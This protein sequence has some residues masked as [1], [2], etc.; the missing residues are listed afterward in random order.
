[1]TLLEAGSSDWVVYPP[2]GAMRPIF[3]TIFC[4]SW[5]SHS[6]AARIWS[7]TDWSGGWRPGTA[8]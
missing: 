8:R 5:K 4:T 3:C 2:I 6:P 1:M 7:L